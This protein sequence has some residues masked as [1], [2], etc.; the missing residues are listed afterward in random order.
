MCVVLIHSFHVQ[1][2]STPLML[3]TMNNHIAIVQYLV[4]RTAEVNAT[5]KVI[6][7]SVLS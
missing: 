7:Y 5:N 4:E 3:A 6:V 1:Y 2:G